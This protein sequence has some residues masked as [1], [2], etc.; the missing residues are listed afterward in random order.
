MI[1]KEC[2][3]HLAFAYANEHLENNSKCRSRHC[4]V[5]ITSICAW[6]PFLLLYQAQQID[7]PDSFALRYSFKRAMQSFAA[8][9]AEQPAH[10]DV[11]SSA[12]QPA[13]HATSTQNTIP[14]FNTDTGSSS[15][16]QPALSIFQTFIL[17]HP[18]NPQSGD[19]VRNLHMLHKAA[20]PAPSSKAQPRT[21][22]LEAGR[23][24]R[25]NV[26]SF[27]TG[28]AS[29]PEVL[30]PNRNPQDPNHARAWR[31]PPRSWRGSHSPPGLAR[32]S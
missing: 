7:I 13:N 18:M 1:Q 32:Y 24:E 6:I 14:L 5:A 3:A 2:A 25:P 23:G 27:A 8:S 29:P 15:A 21:P 10:N 12:A 19:Y 22:Y 30:V 4:W 16:G 31:A 26:T 9:S 11:N 17:H 20:P 28:H